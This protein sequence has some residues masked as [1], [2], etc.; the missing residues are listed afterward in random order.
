MSFAKRIDAAMAQAIRAGQIEPSPAKLA[1]ALHYTVTPG[2]ARIRPSILMS[3]A[4]ACGDPNPAMTD[5][6]ATALELIHWRSRFWHA[7]QSTI[8]CG[9]RS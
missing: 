5:A 7:Q 2:G 3:V 6:A 4:H 8:R 9:P 1:S